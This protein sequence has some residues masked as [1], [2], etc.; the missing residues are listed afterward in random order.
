MQD[1][2]LLLVWK[3]Y[4]HIIKMICTR[5]HS[6]TCLKI[7]LVWFWHIMKIECARLKY[8]NIME[9]WL[10]YNGNV[11]CRSCNISFFWTYYWYIIIILAYNKDLLCRSCPQD[12]LGRDWPRAEHRRWYRPCV[13]P[14]EHPG[15]GDGGVLLR[16]QGWVGELVTGKPWGN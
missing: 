2:N 10:V 6:F 4:W 1:C 9:I 5:L 14:Q 11:V 16:A 3:Y 12:R 13:W 7:L 15:W 8:F